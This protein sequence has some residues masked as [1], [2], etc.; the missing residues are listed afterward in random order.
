MWYNVWVGPDTY[1]GNIF[2]DWENAAEICTSGTCTVQIPGSPPAGNYEI[3]MQA[4]NPVGIQDWTQIT[5]F[6]VMP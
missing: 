6:S 2:F 1:D 3:W 5:S 4:W